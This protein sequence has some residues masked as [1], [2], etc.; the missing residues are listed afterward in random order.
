MISKGKGSFCTIAIVV[1]DF[2]FVRKGWRNLNL[3]L[4]RYHV[5]ESHAR[6]IDPKGF[7]DLLREM[8]KEKAMT[9]NVYF[10]EDVIRNIFSLQE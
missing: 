10:P 6:Y 5:E 8:T 1:H 3:F 4:N 2:I 9:Q 7:Y